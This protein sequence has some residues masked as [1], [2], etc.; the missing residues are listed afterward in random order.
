MTVSL[1]A[2]GMNSNFSSTAAGAEN[3]QNFWQVQQNQENCGMTAFLVGVNTLL[4]EMIAKEGKGR[5]CLN[6]IKEYKFE[7]I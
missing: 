3:G 1:D 6:E 5:A 7:K 2:S 4:G